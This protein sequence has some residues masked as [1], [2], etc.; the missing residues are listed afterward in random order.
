MTDFL[1]SESGQILAGAHKYLSAAR[2]VRYSDEWLRGP[3]LLQT[4][5]LHLLAHGIELLLKFPLL[6]A[7]VSPEDVRKRYG[8]D[9]PRLW[10]DAHNQ[11][12][13]RL[14]LD[15]SDEAWSEAHASGRWPIDDFNKDPRQELLRALEMLGYLHGRESDFA[16][17]YTVAVNTHAPR[18]AFLIDVFGHVAECC[19][20]NPGLFREV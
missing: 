17:R 15:R 5:A 2:I 14:C 8:H 13:R 3:T 20:K 7:G 10:N 19:L 12:T 16:L 9:L 11:A 4:P 1:E 18:P 6:Q